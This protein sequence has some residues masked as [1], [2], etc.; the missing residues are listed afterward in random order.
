[1]KYITF[2]PYTPLSN[3]KGERINKTILNKVRSIL[4]IARIA[5]YLQGKVA[6]TAIYIYNRTLHS[7]LG[8]KSLIEVKENRT[9]IIEDLENIKTFRSI[10]YYKNNSLSS[11]LDQKAYKGIIIGY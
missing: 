8:Y 1:M 7:Y 9:L 2:P 5:Y 4:Y 6:L 3:G 10:I 11:K